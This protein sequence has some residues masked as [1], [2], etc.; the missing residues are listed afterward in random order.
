MLG[1][2]ATM[3]SNR[4]KAAARRLQA[5][6]NIPYAE[7]LRRITG[8]RASARSTP[9]VEHKCD[10]GLWLTDG[11][12]RRKVCPRCATDSQKAR[13]VA[14][15][16]AA[17]DLKIVRGATMS[18]AWRGAGWPYGPNIDL[19]A[20]EALFAWAEPR[21]LRAS[22]TSRSCLHWLQQIP[23]PRDSAGM[24]AEPLPGADHVSAWNQGAGKN[25]AVLV[26]QPYKLD[27]GSRARLAEI[28]RSSGLRVEI[29]NTGGWYGYDTVFVAIWRTD[30]RPTPPSS[31]STRRGPARN[32]A[33]RLACCMC[34]KPVPLRSDVYA[35]DAEWQRRFPDM[36]GTL[37]CPRCALETSWSC[38]QRDS[39]AYVDGHIPAIRVGRTVRNCDAWSHIEPGYGTQR[40]MVWTHPWSGLL[41]GA[42]GY[43]RRLMARHSGGDAEGMPAIVEALSRWDSHQR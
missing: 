15:Q 9:L 20:R 41:Q 38:Y 8:T 13:V 27:A 4:A 23:C 12:D 35:L 26:S 31:G 14:V 30:P 19:D 34:R 32:P 40:A 18:Q 43:L 7:A 1:T 25:P 42:E 33:F 21:G 28:N 29:E 11:H 17:H 10:R 6:E 39:H 22:S 3:T 2:E 37:A 24:C 5:E 36:V 16:K